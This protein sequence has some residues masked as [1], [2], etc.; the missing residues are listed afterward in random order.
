M[1]QNGPSTTGQ[2]QVT[3]LFFLV[4]GRIVRFSGARSTEGG[5]ERAPQEESQK[6][7]KFGRKGSRGTLFGA[8]LTFQVRLRHSF[9]ARGAF[10]LAFYTRFGHFETF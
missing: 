8:N 4:F 10:L 7:T 5:M 6:R 9:C 2:I 1:G 3:R